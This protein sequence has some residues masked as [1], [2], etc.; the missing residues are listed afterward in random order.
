[1]VKRI[2][3]LALR[4]AFL[5]RNHAVGNG[6]HARPGRSQPAPSPGGWIALALT[7]Q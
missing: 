1:M 7:E 5:T 2:V 3:Y 4:M 6:D